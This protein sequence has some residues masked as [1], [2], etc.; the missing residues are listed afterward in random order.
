MPAWLAQQDDENNQ[1]PPHPVL[2][3]R[4]TFSPGGRR[5]AIKHS[6]R[7]AL[8]GRGWIVRQLTDETGETSELIR[9]VKNALRFTTFAQKAPIFGLAAE[10]SGVA[11]P[12]DNVVRHKWCG[13]SSK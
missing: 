3:R 9:Q 11:W 10:G 2:L 6:P 8:A 12:G 13:F 4:T 7:P 1:R 5:S